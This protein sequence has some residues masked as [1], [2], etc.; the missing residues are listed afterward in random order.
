MV[1]I[2]KYFMVLVHFMVHLMVHPYYNCSPESSRFRKCLF[3]S[4]LT[5]AGVSSDKIP[6]LRRFS[7]AQI[8]TWSERC[9]ILSFKKGDSWHVGVSGEICQEVRKIRCWWAEKR[10]MSLEVSSETGMGN[11]SYNWKRKSYNWKITGRADWASSK[12]F[13]SV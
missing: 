7:E 6:T 5:Y 9:R 3:R 12:S 13:F 8:P 10:E 11:T 4:F 2:L 1:N